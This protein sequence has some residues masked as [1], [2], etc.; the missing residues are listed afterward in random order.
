V[1]PKTVYFFLTGND[2]IKVEDR[3]KLSKKF[4]PN[5][6]FKVKNKKQFIS[7]HIKIKEQSK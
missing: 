6:L 3:N 2:I 5:G 1:F 7:E 4:S